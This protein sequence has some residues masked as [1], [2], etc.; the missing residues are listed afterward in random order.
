MEV[1]IIR[2]AQAQHNL[3]QNW[4]IF[5]P[6]I[7]DLG[8]QQC[9]E[10]SEKLVKHSPEMVFVSPS[11]RT[12]ETANIIFKDYPT[13]TTNLLVEYQTG[14]PCNSVDTIENLYKLYPGFNYHTFIGK[15]P[16]K[17]VTWNDGD[18]R[19]QK[20]AD[21]LKCLKSLGK[22]SVALVTHGNFIRNILRA[23]G[24]RFGVN[25]DSK[26]ELGNASYIILTI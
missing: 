13:F 5:D 8:I 17:E 6:V 9:K 4:G 15:L 25:I 16:S 10:T 12:M 2:H 18:I 1:I 22:R 11:K 14:V 19:A 3:T 21:L 7:T 24:D 23:I 20:V 26:E